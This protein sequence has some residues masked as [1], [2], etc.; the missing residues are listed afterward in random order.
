MHNY[1]PDNL[2]L[3]RISFALL[4]QR[5]NPLNQL[6]RPNLQPSRGLKLVAK[7]VLFQEPKGPSP[8]H[9][10]LVKPTQIS[11]CRDLKEG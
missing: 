11:A 9:P 4:Q 10:T 5:S 6:L 2:L 7:Y 1:Q 3:P 8:H